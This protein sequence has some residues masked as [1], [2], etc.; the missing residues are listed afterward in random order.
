MFWEHVRGPHV[1]DWLFA[2]RRGNA[3]DLRFPADGE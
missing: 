3:F 2:V 1:E